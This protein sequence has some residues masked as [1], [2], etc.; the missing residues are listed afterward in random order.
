[1]KYLFILLFSLFQKADTWTITELHPH[2]SRYHNS[3]TVV[4]GDSTMIIQFDFPPAAK[5]FPSK[6]DKIELVNQRK[7]LKDGSQL[8]DIIN[9]IKVTK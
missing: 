2:L 1:M 7:S 8:F 5:H 4:K 6:G 9:V 3:V